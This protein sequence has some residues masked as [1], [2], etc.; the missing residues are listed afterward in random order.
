MGH[1]IAL[2]PTDVEASLPVVDIEV[3]TLS[4]HMRELRLKDQ[5]PDFALPDET[6][7]TH[8]LSDQNGHP[9]VL[10]FYPGDMTPGC[11]FQLC[12]L[13][14]EWSTLSAAG[15]AVYGINPANAESH[16]AFRKAKHFP[17]PLLVDAGKRVSRSYGA[18]TELFGLK[19]IRRTVVIV[20]P[21]GR[22]AYYRH[23]LPKTS[24]L[25][26]ILSTL[27]APSP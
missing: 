14:D 8:R 11:T 17:F 10:V 27:R 24:D 19:L 21:D 4:Q 15:A 25:L 6:G 18:L 12:S 5:A 9:V 20:G 13:R 22:I 16:A 1:T 26:K 7:Q 3:Y 2:R 23:G